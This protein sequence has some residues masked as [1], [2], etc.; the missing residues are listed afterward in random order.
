MGRRNSL[1]AMGR[2]PEQEWH[3]VRAY[4]AELCGWEREGKQVSSDFCCWEE[5]ESKCCFNNT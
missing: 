1:T 2:E 5:N 3:L 4:R